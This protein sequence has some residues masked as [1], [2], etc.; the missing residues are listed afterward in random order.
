MAGWVCAECLTL[1]SV[2]APRCPHCGT[3]EY[4]EEG[5]V[6]KITRQGGPSNAGLDA[7]GL[8]ESLAV[9]PVVTDVPTPDGEAP[10]KADQPE[11]D[12]E[13]DVEPKPDE[14]PDPEPVQAPARKT[15]A[16]KAHP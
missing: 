1:Y 6:P 16:R 3:T 14:E 7:A 8:A 9:E 15:T 4:H 5:S 10:G 13:P 12:V 2:G 11:P